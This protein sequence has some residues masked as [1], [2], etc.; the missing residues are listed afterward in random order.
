M[1][2]TDDTEMKMIL[3]KEYKPIV[4]TSLNK[5]E[6]DAVS[7]SLGAHWNKEIKI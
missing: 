6:E 2:I 7:Y 4:D 1:L 5:D 3:S